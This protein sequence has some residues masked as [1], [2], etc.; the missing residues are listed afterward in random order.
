MLAFVVAALLGL[1]DPQSTP[2]A[3]PQ[4]PS[5]QQT[6]ADASAVRLE[7]VE[8]TARRNDMIRAFVNE[9][10]APNRHRG[11]ARWRKDICIGVA[12]LRPEAAQYIVDRVSTVAEDIGL[13]PGEP[14]CAP[15]V[16]I[17]ASTSADELA[18]ELVRERRQAFRM[19]GSGMDRGAAAL[20]AFVNSDQPVRWW[21]VSMPTDNET[22]ADAVSLPGNCRGSCDSNPAHEPR[23]QDFGPV[24]KLAGSSRLNSQIVDNLFRTVAILDVDQVSSVSIQQLADY[25]A[26]ITLVQIDPGADTSAYVSVLNVFDDPAQTD[27]LTGWDEAY[28]H[29]LYEA[30]RTRRN[31]SAGRS[32]LSASIRRARDRLNT[33][34]PD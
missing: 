13:T 12:N 10:A 30:D 22:G 25:L 31:P 17:I 23:P 16:I 18:A 5:A 26:M 2:P 28:L 4:P 7:D 15:N 19:G 20:T 3:A 33:A 9:V 8:I 27:G 24:I 14:G 34:T 11:I 1:S 32:E 29:G 21:Q 6:S